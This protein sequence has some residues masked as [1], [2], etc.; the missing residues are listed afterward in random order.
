MKH[1]NGKDHVYNV[2]KAWQRL[3]KE[4]RTT[5]QPLPRLEV[6]EEVAIL[7]SIRPRPRLY[8]FLPHTGFFPLVAPPTGPKENLHTISRK[9]T[10][11]V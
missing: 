9:A 4:H 5:G 1:E 6:F 8:L 3:Q 7:N 2:F 11:Y 10:E